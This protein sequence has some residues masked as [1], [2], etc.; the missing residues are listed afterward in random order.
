MK[1]Y[2]LGILGIGNMGQSILSGIIKSS[3]Y[4]KEDICLFDIDQIKVS[5]LK[6]EGFLFCLVLAIVPLSFLWAAITGKS[7]RYRQFT[8]SNWKRRTEGLSNFFFM[9]LSAGFFVEMIIQTEFLTF[10]ET[11]FIE[12]ADYRLL[13]Y[14][15]IGGLF[16]ATSFIGFHPLVSMPLLAALRETILPVIQRFFH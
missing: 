11:L 6:E 2:K 4:N 3:L 7:K 8:L 9:F 1:K 5:K 14:F 12:N 15:M 13:F 10:L 16:F